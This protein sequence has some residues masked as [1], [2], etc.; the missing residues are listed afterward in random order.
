M[1]LA[2]TLDL[3]VLVNRISQWSPPPHHRPY[4]RV[5]SAAATW[6]RGK[7]L[8]GWMGKGALTLL[9]LVRKPT[10]SKAPECTQG[11]IALSMLLPLM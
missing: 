2:L 3:A 11:G 1:D 10:E 7:G 9:Q 8:G 4:D 6:V 5:L